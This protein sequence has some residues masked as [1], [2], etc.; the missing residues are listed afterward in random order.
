MSC[1]Q[2][3]SEASSPSLPFSG[4]L[5]NL[6]LWLIALNE[7]DI[8]LLGSNPD[9]LTFTS[10]GLSNGSLVLHLKDTSPQYVAVQWFDLTLYGNSA[11]F[12]Q[13]QPIVQCSINPAAFQ[14]GMCVC[15]C[16]PVSSESLCSSSLFLCTCSGYPSLYSALNAF[17]FV[18]HVH[19]F[20]SFCL[21]LLCACACACVFAPQGAR[22]S[23]LTATARCH[24]MA[25]C[26]PSHSLPLP[27]PSSSGHDWTHP[28]HP[29]GTQ[30]SLSEMGRVSRSQSCSWIRRYPVCVCVLV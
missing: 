7:R 15:A 5:A 24:R 10:S 20:V 11:R 22:S 8:I 14:P 18:L 3:C 26:P 12:N 28:R 17:V 29:L 13:H 27:S 6:Q 25:S 1:V 21:R 23:S 30:P 2:A 4:D 19:L 9:S 16:G